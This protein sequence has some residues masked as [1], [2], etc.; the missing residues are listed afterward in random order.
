MTESDIVKKNNYSLII[1]CQWFEI[2]TQ[3]INDGSIKIIA[4]NA[5]KSRYEFI[6]SAKEILQLTREAS[7]ELKSSDFYDL[8]I[9]GLSKK[10]P[11]VDIISFPE[12]D[13]LNITIIMDISKLNLRRV[14]VLK[15]SRQQIKDI[16]SMD[17]I[18]KELIKEKEIMSNKIE[19]LEGLLEIEQKDKAQISALVDFCCNKLVDLEKDMIKLRVVY[20]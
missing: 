4:E 16:A 3:L 15:S 18:I 10:D 14:F 20:K 19:N 8:L 6:K 12:L 1:D 7:F 17:K 5:P 9:V 11:N 2:S 13:I